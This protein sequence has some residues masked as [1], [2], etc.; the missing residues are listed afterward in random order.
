MM[1]TLRALVLVRAS[2]S[3]APACTRTSDG[4]AAGDGAQRQT[5]DD[6]G[7]DRRVDGD[8]RRDADVETVAHDRDVLGRATA[9]CPPRR[10]GHRQAQTCVPDVPP[11]VSVVAQVADPGAPTVTVARA[12]G[13][14]DVLGRRR[15]RW[16]HS[17]TART[18]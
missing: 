1:P 4:T 14:V 8:G 17:W 16:L 3:L 15:R 11:P 18:G 9:S 13:L 12:R 10:P 7:A 5:A 2:S 6:R